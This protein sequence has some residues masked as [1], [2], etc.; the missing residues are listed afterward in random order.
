MSAR[1]KNDGPT[2]FDEP[3]SDF[4]RARA[5]RTDPKTSHAAAA[6]VRNQDTLQAFVL[7]ALRKHGPMID[8]R[9]IEVLTQDGHRFTRSGVQ[10]RRK[11][12]VVLGLVRDSG[13]KIPT[14]TNRMA[15]VWEA[16]P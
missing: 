6:S 3:R 9:L 1:K 11:E 13:R 16:V 5:R 2:F 10:T 4:Q 7:A 14:E 8:Y 15:I 12:L